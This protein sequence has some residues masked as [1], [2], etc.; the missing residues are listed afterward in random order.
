MKECSLRRIRRQALRV[1]AA[2]KVHG[3]VLA[4]QPL[5]ASAGCIGRLIESNLSIRQKA[6]I[7]PD[8]PRPG[9]P[10]L[11]KQVRARRN[12]V[13]LIRRIRPGVCLMTLS[14]FFTTFSH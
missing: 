13:H 6:H 9:Q 7:S 10:T 2:L 11:K 5:L 4:A 1:A 12:T 8:I 14:I 3:D